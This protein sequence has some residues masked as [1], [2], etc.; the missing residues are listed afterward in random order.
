M[1]MGVEKAD[2]THSLIGAACLP[3]SPCRHRYH[4][5]ALDP[6]PI[7]ELKKRVIAL[8]TDQLEAEVTIE[9]LMGAYSRESGSAAPA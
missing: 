6:A 1:A 7:G 3:W 2:E 4:R 9:T 8:L 5:A